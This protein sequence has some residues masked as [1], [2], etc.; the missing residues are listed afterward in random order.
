MLPHQSKF[1]QSPFLFPEKRFFFNVAGYGAGKSMSLTLTFLH[2]VSIL[3]GKKDRAGHH[4]RL[5]LGGVNLG[6]LEKTTLTY[7]KEELNNSNTP[8]TYDKKNNKFIVGTVTTM[9]ISLSAPDSIVGFDCVASLCD[10]IDDLPTGDDTTFEAVR[11][12]NER[13]RQNVQDFRT[14]FLLFASTSQGQR[15]LY[16]VVTN[17]RKSGVGFVLIRGSSRENYHH[18]P[19]YVDSLYKMYNEKERRVYLEGYFEALA[20]GRVFGDFDWDRNYVNVAM[21]REIGQHEK[22]VWAQDFNCQ[23]DF[24]MIAT[25]EGLKRLENI[26]VGDMVLTRKGY[27]KCLVKMKRLD[28]IIVK[29]GKTWSTLDHPFIDEQGEVEAWKVKK[30]YYLTVRMWLRQKLGKTVNNLNRLLVLCLMEKSTGVTPEMTTLSTMQQNKCYTL[31]FTNTSKVKYLTGML[32]IIKTVLLTTAL[33]VLRVLQDKNTLKYTIQEKELGS[34]GKMGASRLQAWFVGYVV[35]HLQGA[36]KLQKFAQKTVLENTQS[37]VSVK[38]KALFRSKSV[39]GRFGRYV[40]KTVQRLLSQWSRLV[41]IVSL[42]M[43]AHLTLSTA[44]RALKPVMTLANGHTLYGLKSPVW[45]IE[46]EGEHEYFADGVLVHNS[47][48]HRGCVGVLRGNIIYI[49][50]RYEFPDI[51]EAPKVVRHDFPHNRIIWVP[52]TTAKDQIIQFTRELHKYGIWWITRGRNPNVEDSAFLCLDAKTFI[53]TYN[54]ILVSRKRIDKLIPGE[55]A[56]TRSG[57]KKILTVKVTGKRKVMGLDRLRLTHDHEVLSDDAWVH[58]SKAA[59]VTRYNEQEVLLWTLKTRLSS[60]CLDV[61]AYVSKQTEAFGTDTQT[62]KI[63]GLKTII[64]AIIQTFHLVGLSHYTDTGGLKQTVRFLKDVRYIIKMEIRLTMLWKILSVLRQS[65][66]LRYTIKEEIYHKEEVASTKK[67][68]L[69]ASAV[70]KCFMLGTSLQGIVRRTKV[71]KHEKGMLENKEREHDTQKEQRPVLSVRQRLNMHLQECVS[72]ALQNALQETEQINT[73]MLESTRSIVLGA[74]RHTK[75]TI[76]QENTAQTNVV[77]RRKE[78][79]KKRKVVDIEVEDVHEFLA[80][81]IIVHNCNKLLYTGRLICTQAAQETAEALSLAMRD[82]NN[83]IPS[84]K[85]PSSPIHDCLCGTTLVKTECGYKRLEAIK[86]GDKVLT[87][88]GYKKVTAVFDKGVLP[89]KNYVGVWATKDHPFY[90]DGVGMKAC[91]ELTTEEL[92][93][94]LLYKEHKLW[95]LQSYLEILNLNLKELCL[96]GLYTIDTQT[97]LQNQKE[98]IINPLKVKGYTSLCGSIIMEIF[99][100]VCM[101]ITKMKTPSTTGLK[102]LNFLLKKSMK[103]YHTKEELNKAGKTLRKLLQKHQNGIE[104]KKGVL[105]I[106]SMHRQ[107]VLG[108]GKKLMLF[109]RNVKQYLRVKLHEQSF[110]IQNVNNDT[111]MPEDRPQG[112]EELRHVYDITVEDAHE[113]FANG[114]L[115]SN[116]DSVRMM[117]YFI[118]VTERAMLDIKK[119]TIARHLEYMKNEPM[120]EELSD[121]YAAINP[122]AVNA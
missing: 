66:T 41:S 24:T 116:C 30:Y 13:T 79:A 87:R 95:K 90:V 25:D 20:Q 112:K 51:R 39:E 38:Q 111:T 118:C 78:S 60:L 19:G 89:T 81:G 10:E 103:Y 110:V 5:L 9:L 106:K 17:F 22:I 76:I 49:V 101:F 52:D 35:K 7:I 46:V 96:R 12:V 6:H 4:A 56:F 74:D 72:S 98:D 57:W 71:Q 42:S 82:K 113:F 11:A 97:D 86:V 33:K 47:G 68:S 85:G 1:M 91:G 114:V 44:A 40:G 21:D 104:V 34:T 100:K 84:G 107:Q 122:E 26:T 8:F 93:Q 70:E 59:S 80:Q 48:Y 31:T 99:Q 64:R 50:K 73:E 94:I 117:C 105:G 115:V 55:Y 61:K 43:K 2:L 108:Y 119:T 63:Q 18:P 58:A 3:Q 92:N 62:Q 120:I 77:K 69:F 29:T 83:Q 37:C 32:Y 23:P 14:P 102:I 45:D 36:S 15:G 67:A 28:N 88:K 27:R 16:R 53:L 75:Q 54:G 121:G 65:S 109:V